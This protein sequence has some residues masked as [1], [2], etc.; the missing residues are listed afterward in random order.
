MAS[1]DPTP[2]A[3]A[4]LV[5]V[6]NATSSNRRDPADTGPVPESGANTAPAPTRSKNPCSSIAPA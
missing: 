2:S 6:N 5:A 3:N 1:T 4:I